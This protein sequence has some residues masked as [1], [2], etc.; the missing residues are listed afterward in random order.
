MLKDRL[1]MGDNTFGVFESTE[2][3]MIRLAGALET[4]PGHRI[5]SVMYG[6]Y[7][8]RVYDGDI[9]FRAVETPVKMYENVD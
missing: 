8:S 5:G 1:G 4:S 7:P 2:A 3:V 6:S 9:C